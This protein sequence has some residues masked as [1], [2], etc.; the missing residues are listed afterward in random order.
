MVSCPVILRVEPA[1]PGC[2]LKDALVNSVDPE[3]RA[4]EVATPYPCLH[5]SDLPNH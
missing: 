5:H 3:C 2:R 1:F 4:L